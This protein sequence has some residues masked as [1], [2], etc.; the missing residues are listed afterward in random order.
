[1]KYFKLISAA[2]L[3]LTL[4]ACSNG[5]AADAPVEN[6]GAA[7]D[8]GTN[9]PASKTDDKSSE[10]NGEASV[11]YGTNQPDT[12]AAAPDTNVNGEAEADYGT[13]ENNH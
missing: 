12:Q 9:E 11:D 6:G 10:V 7:V 4:A 3:A 5:T 8:Y 2:A 13:A 1:M